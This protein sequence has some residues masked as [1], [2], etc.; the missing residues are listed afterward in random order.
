MATNQNDGGPAFPTKATENFGF[1]SLGM[2]L[3]DWF[4]GQALEGYIA[5]SPSDAYQGSPK[6][7][8][9][10]AYTMAEA[11]IAEKQRRAK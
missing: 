1:D 5:W 9:A 2:S 11:M 4:A 3:L 7:S 8:A 10:F 6:D